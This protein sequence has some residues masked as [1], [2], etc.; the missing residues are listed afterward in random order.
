VVPNDGDLGHRHVASTQVLAQ[1][2][3]GLRGMVGTVLGEAE[4]HQG[5][6]LRTEFVGVSVR[7]ARRLVLPLAEERLALRGEGRRAI[8]GR[9]G[10]GCSALAGDGLAKGPTRSPAT[11]HRSRAGIVG[12][13]S[14]TPWRLTTAGVE[15]HAMSTN[16]RSWAGGSRPCACCARH[17]L[18]PRRRAPTRGF[19]LRLVR[20]HGRGLGAVLH[21]VTAVRRGA[22]RRA[23]TGAEAAPEPLVLLPILLRVAASDV[24]NPQ[25]F[26]TPGRTRTCDP[27]L[28]AGLESRKVGRRG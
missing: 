20:R 22:G 14:A 4:I 27:R 3:G 2:E 1:V 8:A 21:E 6:A 24:R 5:L 12:S 11:V 10:G 19:R 17:L 9:L 15:A 13:T 7:F 18:G 26:R 16:H 28:R 23:V 25:S